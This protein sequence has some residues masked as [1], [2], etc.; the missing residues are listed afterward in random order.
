MPLSGRKGQRRA[1]PD[2]KPQPF[3]GR[4][5]EVNVTRSRVEK[6][7]CRGMIDPALDCNSLFRQEIETNE[8]ERQ[9]AFKQK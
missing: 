1:V 3:R 4:F 6:K 5:E 7:P 9:Q 2:R 8:K